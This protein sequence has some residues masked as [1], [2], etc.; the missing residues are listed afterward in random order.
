MVWSGTTGSLD[1]APTEQVS[2]G[3]SKLVVPELAK[4]DLLP[5]G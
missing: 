5:R 3:V 1:P 4:A 2:R